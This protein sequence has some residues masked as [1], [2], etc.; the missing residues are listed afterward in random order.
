MNDR[1]VTK[2]VNV[3]KFEKVWGAE[4]QKAVSTD[5]HSQIYAYSDYYLI[6]LVPFLY[7]SSFVIFFFWSKVLGELYKKN[8][9]KC[10]R[11]LNMPL[12]PG[13]TFFSPKI[14]I[15]SRLVS[16]KSF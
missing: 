1:K 9:K 15:K 3:I 2:I 16:D 12:T 14:N 6:L 4:K 8:Y 7:Y 10:R 11:I 13:S 5:N